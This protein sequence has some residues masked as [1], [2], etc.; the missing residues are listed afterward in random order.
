ML[1]L[2]MPDVE[3]EAAII[4]LTA[5]W[6]IDLTIISWMVAS[7]AS[8][9]WISI[10]G[11]HS[12]QRWGGILLS[13]IACVRVNGTTSHGCSGWL[14]V[15]FHGIQR[16]RSEPAQLLRELISASVSD[17]TAD[18][19]F[20]AASIVRDCRT[21]KPIAIEYGKICLKPHVWGFQ[22]IR[23]SRLSM[24]VAASDCRACTRFRLIAE[25]DD[26]SNSDAPAVV[27]FDRHQ[28]VR[29]SCWIAQLSG[30]ESMKSDG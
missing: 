3:A 17:G 15:F 26:C 10:A 28:S 22:H 29:S 20:Q 25:S 4:Q 23:C 8:I 21:P 12:D 13:R 16:K 1:L 7:F 9:S 18:W 30:R 5:G 11:K 2:R 24:S 27:R 19:F 6:R 14:F